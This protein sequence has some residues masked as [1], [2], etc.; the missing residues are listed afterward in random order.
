MIFTVTKKMVIPNTASYKNEWNYKISKCRQPKKKTIDP[1]QQQVNADLHELITVMQQCYQTTTND[2][3]Y[4][5]HSPIRIDT[6]HAQ[7]NSIH[8]N[9][10]WVQYIW[11]WNVEI[12]QRQTEWC[13]T[14]RLTQQI[15]D[16]IFFSSDNIWHISFI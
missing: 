15:Q 5:E 10:Y 2:L 11:R 9:T 14:T 7:Y 1:I 4:N 16:S 3:D 13:T 12:S 6:I 8:I